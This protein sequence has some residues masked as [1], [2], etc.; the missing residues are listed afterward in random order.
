MRHYLPYN[1]LQAY[2]NIGGFANL[3]ILY[4]LMRSGLLSFFYAPAI[5]F[6]NHLLLAS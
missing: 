1:A 4:V 3:I 2:D 5:A 6:F